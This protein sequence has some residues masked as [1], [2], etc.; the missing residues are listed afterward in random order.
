MKGIWSIVSPAWIKLVS[1]VFWVLAWVISLTKLAIVLDD[2]G[3]AL[4]LFP[5]PGSRVLVYSAVPDPSCN[6]ALKQ[7]AMGGESFRFWIFV[8]T[9]IAECVLWWAGLML[10]AIALPLLHG[11]Y[12]KRAL[13]N[14]PG[15]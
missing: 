3:R 1:N 9:N 6:F 4:P 12:E 13:N 14:L 8:S 5:H 11:I 7:L 2:T 15:C 10:V